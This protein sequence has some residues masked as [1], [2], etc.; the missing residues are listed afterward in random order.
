MP[1]FYERI[2]YA[3]SKVKGIIHNLKSLEIVRSNVR[4]HIVRVVNKMI[5][6]RFY[7]ARMHQK[8]NSFSLV[9]ASSLR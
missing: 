8:N 4:K 7:W 1:S 2:I 9:Q 3:V 6:E 5:K